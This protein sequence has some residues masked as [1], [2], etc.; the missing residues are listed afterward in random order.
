[1][2]RYG[3]TDFDEGL[4]QYLLD[5]H[6]HLQ[7]CGEFMGLSALDFILEKVRVRAKEFNTILNISEEALKQQAIDDAAATYRRTSEGS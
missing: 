1:M 3:I 2:A 7:Y 5:L 4:D 6:S